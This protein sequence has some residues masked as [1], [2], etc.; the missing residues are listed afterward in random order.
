MHH[1][2]ILDRFTGR[3]RPNEPI[4]IVKAKMCKKNTA[5]FTL[6]LPDIYP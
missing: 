5:G 3:N 6:K 2:R 4:N 1:E